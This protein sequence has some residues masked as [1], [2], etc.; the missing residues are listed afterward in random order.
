MRTPRKFLALAVALAMVLCLL[1]TQLAFAAPTSVDY[2]ETVQ[3]QQGVNVSSSVIGAL[4]A[5]PTGTYTY[6]G[7]PSLPSGFA[8]ASN[9]DVT[10]AG[11]PGVGPIILPVVVTEG[12]TPTNLSVSIPV[13][14]P[15]PVPQLTSPADGATGV[16]RS[17]TS[18]TLTVQNPSVLSSA[19]TINGVSIPQASATT[20]DNLNFVFPIPGS[21]AANT[22]YT[23]NVPQGA[24]ALQAGG[25]GTGSAEVDRTFTTAAAGTPTS[26]SMSIASPSSVPVDSAQATSGHQIALV[27]T[28]GFPAHTTTGL[29]FEVLD[30]ASGNTVSSNF[31]ILRGSLTTSAVQLAS[32]LPIG[33]YTYR[34]RASMAGYETSTSTATSFTVTDAKPTVAS[35]SPASGGT[36]TGNSLQLDFCHPIAA[37]ASIKLYKGSTQV[38]TLTGVASGA[39]AYYN[40]SGIT[41]DPGTTYSYTT[42]GFAHAG[43][44][45]VSDNATRTFLTSGSSTA[46]NYVR[47][48]G[49]SCLPSTSSISAASSTTAS[50]TPAINA[51]YNYN[52]YVASTGS[53]SIN[54][55]PVTS[56][57]AYIASSY[58]LSVGSVG[59]TGGST[60]TVSSGSQPQITLSIPNSALVSQTIPVTYTYT[61]SG[62]S[63]TV[64][65]NVAL[66]V[67]GAYSPAVPTYN[68]TVTM[69]LSMNPTSITVNTSAVLTAS[70]SGYYGTGYGYNNYTNYYTSINGVNYFYDP[71]NMSYFNGSSWV[72]LGTTNYYTTSGM[73]ISS[74][75]GYNSL[76]GSYGNAL[77]NYYI[78]WSGSYY[79]Y[80]PSNNT[81]YNG[82]AWVTSP[83]TSYNTIGNMSLSNFVGYNYN[84]NYGNYGNLTN[85][86]I[87]FTLDPTHTGTATI[88]Q[89]GTQSATFKA[90]QPGTYKVYCTIPSNQGFTLSDSNTNTTGTYGTY[91][92]YGHLSDLVA[93]TPGYADGYSYHYYNSN[94]TI[95]TASG[96]VGYTLSYQTVSSTSVSATSIYGYNT[97]Y[98][99]GLISQYVV[100]SPGYADGY[101][102]HF[103]NN[104]MIYTSGGWV[105]FS[106]NVQLL[107]ASSYAGQTYGYSTTSYNYGTNY[108]YGLTKYFLVTVTGSG[109]TTTT[110]PTIVIDD[111]TGGTI[112]KGSYVGIP[113]KKGLTVYNSSGS[114]IGTLSADFA[115][116]TGDI[117]GNRAPIAFNGGTGYVLA[118]YLNILDTK[119][120]AEGTFMV[121][122]VKTYLNFRTSASTSSKALS[123]LTNGTVV[124]AYKGVTS[125]IFTKGMS[126]GKVG[127]FATSYLKAK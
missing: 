101:S 8:I 106:T 1:P 21:L 122:N 25:G 85:V 53:V 82:S 11:T 37:A 95:Y 81:Y 80:N 47:V 19:V 61:I 72:Y 99:G 40:L 127:W 121:V 41:L 36:L 68:N 115:I 55:L 32:S 52:N 7:G 124:I 44:T 15:R 125:G 83:T 126:N 89:Y 67:T 107:S 97:S 112:P 110:D 16:D 60:A 2:T 113:T 103:Y 119:T 9:G 71:A 104:G 24:F 18:F 108:T 96:W 26:I 49:S 88:A 43:G 22:T 58:S 109:T 39:S 91:G 105:S 65:C 77:S 29:T 78:Y 102:Y 34:V 94:G 86:P 3:L 64:T 45:A 48:T 14:P 33:V 84:Y 4:V 63:T 30:G 23:I 100:Y 28:T 123:K 5:T 74:I 117:V 56:A 31:T 69:A 59:G 73:N 20:I 51:T 93:Y 66:T 120:E 75:I 114:Q 116:I 118:G 6:S 76:G 13:L 87:T 42:N 62:V 79:F 92:T 46:Y 12:T 54:F 35:S 27:D 17:T 10:Y 111:A 50:A 57:G 90:T 98:S 70:L 38:A